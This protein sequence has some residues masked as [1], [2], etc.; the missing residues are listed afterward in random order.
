MPANADRYQDSIALEVK[1]GETLIAPLYTLPEPEALHYYQR[2]SPTPGDFEKLAKD[3]S[4]MWSSEP[5]FTAADLA[6]IK[7]LL[8]TWH[9]NKVLDIAKRPDEK[10]NDRE[11]YVG[12]SAAPQPPHTDASPVDC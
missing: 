7:G 1:E 9:Q 3:M 4:A 12:G 6:K 11:F 8:T 10:S 2:L 5:N